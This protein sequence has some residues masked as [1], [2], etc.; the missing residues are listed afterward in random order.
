MLIEE[1]APVCYNKPIETRVDYGLFTS[2]TTEMECGYVPRPLNPQQTMRTGIPVSPGIAV[3]RAYCV[4][5]PLSWDEPH[6]LDAAALSGEIQ[7]F[8]E[9][10]SAAVHELDETIARVSQEI[11]DDEAAIFRSH[12]LLLR[13]PTLVNKVKN[14]IRERRV[15]AA[16]ALHQVLDE[17]NKLNQQISD[18]YLQERMADLRD[19][20]ARLLGQ[21]A[22]NAPGPTLDVNEPVILVA[23]EILPSQALNF[24]RRFVA[25]ILTEKGGATGHAAIL[26]RALGI[27]AVSGLR[28]LLREVHCGD[29]IALDGREG[30]VYLNPGPE[31]EAAYRK[32]EREYVDLSAKLIGNREQ[33]PVTPDGQRIELLANVNNPQDAEMAGKVGASGVGLYRTEYLFLTHPSVP[34]EEEQVAAYTA[35]IEAAPNKTVTI[36]TLDLGGDK[37]V[38][39]F[40]HHSEPN[41]F[42]GFRSIRL[43]SAYPEFFQTQLRAI[44][45]AGAQGK[46]S[47]LFPMISTLEEVLRLKRVVQRVRN[48]LQEQNIPHAC[49]LPVGVMLEVPAAAVCIHRILD[50]VDFV[51][52]GSNDLVQ[53]LMAAD[54]DNPKVA[55]LCEPFSPALMNVLA[56]VIRAC[57]AK[58]KPVTL[59]GEMAGRP[60]CFLP[61][62]GMGLRRLSMSPAFVP[63]IKELVRHTPA[64]FAR[65]VARRVLRMHTS[66]GIRTYLTE[67]VQEIWPNVNIFDMR[68]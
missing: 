49:E 18:P 34:N 51:S 61:L 58:N 23:P 42:M 10:C 39:Y 68:K 45:R 16:T 57:V 14:G 64:D 63:S 59:C 62:F 24:D 7:R 38:P 37:H 2:P 21:L 31:V 46:V 5:H 13:D 1:I 12:R 60:R 47:L 3:A 54:R 17:Y 8:E 4:E 53:Y 28:G 48:G 44:L 52:I 25:G 41:P 9:A 56:R 15:D 50:E 19:V 65:K 22:R 30:H 20:M 55:H 36:R 67:K 6:H 32:L 40:Q 66:K 33:E 43:A 27:P 11:G 26:A 29:L 35:I